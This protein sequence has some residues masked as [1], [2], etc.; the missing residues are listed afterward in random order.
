[1]SV[2]RSSH[3]A[4]GF[5][6]R[7]YVE[8]LALLGL[9]FVLQTG[10]VPFDFRLYG[11]PD[12]QRR[13][14][15]ATVN[16]F[17]LPDIM[18]N[19]FLYVPLG[20]L[21]HW[22]LRRRGR[23]PIR[24][25]LTT[26][27]WGAALSTVV[28]WLQA[29]SPERVSSLIDLVSNVIGAGVGAALSWIGRSIIPRL[30]GA[31]LHE[32]RERPRA[33]L[34]KTYVVVLVVFAAIPFSLS[35]DVARFKQAIK[36]SVFV[37]FGVSELDRIAERA[38]AAGDGIVASRLAWS[39]WK[40]WSR[41]AAEGA[42]FAVFAWLLQPVLRGDYRFRRRAATA[43]TWWCGGAL[44]VGL[45]VLQLPIV[46]RGCD[47]S[48]VLF[49]LLGV[50]V[51]LAAQG[52][53]RDATSLAPIRGE[54][55]RRRRATYVA[56]AAAVFIVYNGLI[57]FRFDTSAAGPGVSLASRGFLP[58]F[59]YFLARFDLMMADVM[60]KFASYAI[61]AAALA[62]FWS[63]PPQ[64]PSRRRVYEI[65]TLGLLLASAIE[66]VQMFMPVRVVSL[67]DL[68]LALA[69]CVA[70]LVGQKHA[71]RF[72]RYATSHRMFGPIPQVVSD[73]SNR[74]TSVDELIA[75]LTE[76]DPNAPVERLP[77]PLEKPRR[78]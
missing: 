62:T 33:S 23:G 26:L 3:S 40:R 49:R 37:P 69:G 18:S 53:Y 66:V 1:M 50:L 16:D 9:L 72:Y 20:M 65:V 39:Q 44:A 21:A 36:A 12:G 70:G 27:V 78:P 14:F 35:F 30:I 47:V 17:T 59:A 5:F 24:A 76:V 13:F 67:T 42:S 34:F 71:A 68:I 29:F 74:L 4:A 61:L 64:G 2:P 75:T 43:L 60:E 48:D 51:G 11:Q 57:P 22:A 73:A 7:R 55:Q 54:D 52:T 6:A 41:W 58:F 38:A 8:L 46:S 10:L 25:W 15:I 31:A 56:F 63:R 32:F 45:S 19:I 28:E 77:A